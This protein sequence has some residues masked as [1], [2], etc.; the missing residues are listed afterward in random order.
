MYCELTFLEN[1][2]KW[3]DGLITISECSQI[4]LL[5]ILI[6]LKSSL[7]Y[8]IC[9][10]IGIFNELQY[11]ETLQILVVIFPKYPRPKPSRLPSDQCHLRESCCSFDTP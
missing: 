3:S 6:R 9:K 10:D 5:H 1:F 4:V 8:F 11:Q 2:A 7:G